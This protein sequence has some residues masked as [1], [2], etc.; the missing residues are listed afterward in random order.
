M[1]RRD[2]TQVLHELGE[3]RGLDEGVRPPACMAISLGV[4]RPWAIARRT[5]SYVRGSLNSRLT[6]SSAS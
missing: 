4:T 2:H 1:S 6:S 3:I 5:V